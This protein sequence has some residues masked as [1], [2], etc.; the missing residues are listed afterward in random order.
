MVHQY[1]L[2]VLVTGA[3]G[4]LGSEIVRQAVSA[5]LVMRATDRHA[6]SITPD[7]DYRPADILDLSSLNSVFRDVSI[8]VHA[9]GLAHIFDK[10][11]ALTAPF[12]AINEQGTANVARAAAAAGVR[13]FILISSVSVY[14]P[15]THGTYDESAPCRPEGPY[16]E[17]KY[18]AE[19]RAI[20]IAQRS[21]MALTI[22]RLATLYGEGDP[23]NVA[24]LMRTIDRGRFVWVGDGSNC[25]SLL[26][27][28][29]AAR[30]ILAVSQQP[31]SGI[32]IYNVAAPPCTMRQVV[33][34]LAAALNRRPFPLRIP[35][36]GVSA[37][38][39]LAA[40]LTRGRGKLGAWQGTLAKWLADDVYDASRFERTMNFQ[41]HVS[42]SEGL[43]REVAWYRSQNRRA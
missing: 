20:E 11:Q 42:L 9:A 41:T 14:G 31:A 36:S 16:A 39:G 19:Q 12:K 5:Q 32:A 30:A 3:K 1:E 18:Q 25:K 29:D 33:D 28:G 6:E 13:H 27:K 8:V 2:P 21:G 4:F 7:V 15:F 40:E 35:A 23:G 43:R 24:R 10:S 17:S 38:I 26:Y 34:G 22:L 37:A